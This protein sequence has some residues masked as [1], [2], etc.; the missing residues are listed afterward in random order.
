MLVTIGN[1]RLD[2]LE[3]GLV[4]ER[5]AIRRVEARLVVQLAPRAARLPAVV[6]L[7][8][9]EMEEALRSA[10]AETLEAGGLLGGSCCCCC[11]FLTPTSLK[12]RSSS[13]SPRDLSVIASI[14]ASMAFCDTSP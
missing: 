8:R 11:R 1:H 13:D 10:L 2:V 12:P 9:D 6:D 7:H 4:D 3:L 5:C 14:V